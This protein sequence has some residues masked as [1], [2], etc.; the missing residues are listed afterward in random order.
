[1]YTGSICICLARGSTPSLAVGW[2]EVSPTT[3]FSS[4]FSW[5]SLVITQ[6]KGPRCHALD[7]VTVP[8]CQKWPNS[9]HWTQKPMSC[10]ETP[11]PLWRLSWLPGMVS[12]SLV[13]FLPLWHHLFCQFH[14]A[15][16]CP[17][18]CS[19]AGP[20]VIPRRVHFWCGPCSGTVVPFR[21]FKLSS[22]L[23]CSFLVTSSGVP[24]C[25]LS[26]CSLSSVWDLHILSI[27]PLPS[28]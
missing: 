10:L 28:I 24:T 8:L 1:M 3:Y 17:M 14:G 18:K 27:S 22:C 16:T 26:L 4:V 23:F 12:W 11:L 15:F 5:K 7:D 21:T 6:L 2:R 20:M 25:L 19:S 13:W 9:L